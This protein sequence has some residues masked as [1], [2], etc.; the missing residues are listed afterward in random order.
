MRS[1]E[2]E[3]EVIVPTASLA[4]ARGHEEIAAALGRR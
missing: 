2:A 1:F 3:H 4:A